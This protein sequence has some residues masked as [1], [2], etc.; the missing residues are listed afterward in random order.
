MS[1]FRDVIEEAKETHSIA[2]IRKLFPK[3]FSQQIDNQEQIIDEYKRIEEALKNDERLQEELRKVESKDAGNLLNFLEKELHRLEGEKRAHALYLLAERE[4]YSRTAATL[5]RVEFEEQ[6]RSDAITLYLENILI[7]GI[8]RA[9]DDNSREY[10]RTVARKID[11]KASKTVTFDE[12]VE[13]YSDES[14]TEDVFDESLRE[15]EIPDEKVVMELLKENMVPQIM[16]RIKNEQL[17]SQQKKYLMAAHYDL[18]HE[19][20][21]NDK[22]QLERQMCVDILNDIIELAAVDDSSPAESCD[23]SSSKEA[24]V[25]AAEIVSQVLNEIIEANFEFSASTTE[26]SSST[27]SYDGDY[28]NVQSTSDAESNTELLAIQVVQS[29]LNEILENSLSST[30][31]FTETQTSDTN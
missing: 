12:Q 22:L 24:E 27:G 11:R 14:N 1:K 6:F 30:T 19:E 23:S 26:N 8:H 9:A 31:E 7:E 15:E 29:V 10:I 20:F 13:Q 3:E 5:G 28:S 4:R 2:A 16:D 25:L 18:F 17:L 21:E